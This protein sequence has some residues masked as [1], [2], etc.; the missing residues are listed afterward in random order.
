MLDEVITP[1]GRGDLGVKPPAKACNC[2]LLLPPVEQKESDSAYCQIT[3]VLVNSAAA[4]A[5]AAT[6]TTRPTTTTTTMTTTSSSTDCG[7]VVVMEAMF[8]HLNQSPSVA[9]L[10][11]R[12]VSSFDVLH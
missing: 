8:L 9:N 5:A 1:R 11:Q 10:L 6:A 7:R 3:L 2:K 12:T 4:T